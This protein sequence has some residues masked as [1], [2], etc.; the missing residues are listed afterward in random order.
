MRLF[1]PEEGLLTA[2]AAVHVHLQPGGEQLQLALWPGLNS[3]DLQREVDPAP[4]LILTIAG[5]LQ[6]KPA[7]PQDQGQLLAVLNDL[8]L[9]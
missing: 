5:H 3:W 4:W 7:N 2:E 6:V 1:L 8:V 9:A